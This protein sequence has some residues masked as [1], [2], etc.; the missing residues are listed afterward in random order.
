MKVLV[1]EDDPYTRKALEEILTGDGYQVEAVSDGMAAWNA[2]RN[3]GADFACLDV[4]MPG[5]SGYDV[6]RK[7]RDSGSTIPVL[8]V[9]AKSEEIDTVL[10]LELG[11]DDYIAKPFGAREL[12]ARIRAILRRAAHSEGGEADNLTRGLT[13]QQNKGDKQQGIDPEA[14]TSSGP[15]DFGPWHVVP[16]ELRAHRE[17]ST[18]ADLSPREVCLMYQLVRNRGKVVSRTSFFQSCWGWDSAPQSRTLDQHIAVLRKKIEN[19]PKTPQLI[20]TVQGVGYRMN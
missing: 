14:I 6:C 8:F 9:S 19:D 2:F 13:A 11:A 7:I 16:S 5:L 10:G 12:S 18:A 17:G 3:G 15:F 20:E 1:A 4:M